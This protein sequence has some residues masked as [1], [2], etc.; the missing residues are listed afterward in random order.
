MFMRSHGRFGLVILVICGSVVGALCGFVVGR[1][2]LVRTAK[3]NLTEYAYELTRA[4]ND[5]NDEM[6][7]IFHRVSAT[8]SPFCSDADLREL[9]GETFRSVTVKD[10]GRIRDGK[11]YCSAFLGRLPNPYVDG[12]ATLVLASKMKVFTRVAI[13]L[14]SLHGGYG[15]VIESDGVDVVLDPM[16]FEHWN[17]QDVQYAIA[18]VRQETGQI[19][20][21]DGSTLAIDPS[22]P[23]SVGYRVEHGSLYRTVCSDR[24]PFCVVTAERV[25]DI[26]SRSKWTQ[27]AYTFVFGHAGL[28]FGLLIAILYRRNGVHS[29]QLHRAIRN[30]SP[31]LSLVYQPIVD[32][33]SGRSVGAEALIR[34]KDEAGDAIPP[35]VFVP[36]A[37]GGGFINELTAF[38][39][40]HTTQDLGDLLR[41]HRDFCLSINIAASDLNDPEF[42]KILSK[43]V[44][45]AGILPQQ[46]T[47]ELTER[48]TSDL[49]MV[50]AAIR[51]LRGQGYKVHIDDFGTG[52]SSLS[53]L[54]QLEVKAIKIDRAFTRTI[55]TDAA[56]APM[57]QQMIAMAGSLGVEV[58]VE[59]VETE[60]QRD[61]LIA[62]NEPLRAQG[63]FYSRPLTAEGIS[64]FIASKD[65]ENLC[66]VEL[67]G[68]P[69]K[70]ATED[71]DAGLCGEEIAL[72]R[73]K[74]LSNKSETEAAASLTI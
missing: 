18:F 29:K 42:Y 36:L 35:D 23:L 47:L 43:H 9:Q 55:G 7:G 65:T 44:P 56:I 34:W 50:R 73:L 24:S 39:I 57:L 74:G 33:S 66:S 1:V 54:D 30:N 58:V 45:D 21:L 53:Y 13:V 3:A 37:E 32:V 69:S 5:L 38:V 64:S 22:R 17:R 2:M 41:S 62:T 26:W 51:K 72:G 19:A 71:V 61:Y 31:S 48:S 8:D 20:V 67:N 70:P 14:A 68:S 63:W 49:T 60:L 52:Y 46:M 6:S 11:L 25:F 16:A 10:V 15:T 27:I 40:R 28:G 59:G 12:N 4:G